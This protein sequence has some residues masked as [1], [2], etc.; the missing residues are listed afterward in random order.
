M[1]PKLTKSRLDL[2]GIPRRQ[3]MQ[4]ETSSE[5]TASSGSSLRHVRDQNQ[6]SNN[7]WNS[8]KLWMA[9]DMDLIALE[10]QLATQY[11]SEMRKV[12]KHLK[13]HRV[14]K[15]MTGILT[16]SSTKWELLGKSYSN[17]QI[18]VKFYHPMTGFCQNDEKRTL[19]MDDRR[20]RSKFLALDSSA[21]KYEVFWT[22]KEAANLIRISKV[23]SINCPQLIHNQDN[24]IITTV[25][26]K[27]GQTLNSL[28]SKTTTKAEW[29]SIY[30]QTVD[31]MVNIWKDCDLCPINFN[32]TKLTLIGD[33][34]YLLSFADFVHK[35]HQ[36]S[37][38]YLLRSCLNIIRVS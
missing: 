13:T 34:I 27:Y 23:K 22:D 14:L 19:I 21:R 31:L 26:G 12:S 8:D 32:A 2:N 4:S 1:N 16:E 20:F 3:T 25:V 18:I 35:L 9:S 15:E 11:S 6:K 24:V 17:Q 37:S 33:Q 38:D 36:N 29:Y 28:D 5:S 7:D 30:E 10:T